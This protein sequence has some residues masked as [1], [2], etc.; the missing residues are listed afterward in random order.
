M[1]SKLFQDKNFYRAM[2]TLSTPIIIQNLITFSLGAVDMIMI[3]QLGDAPVAAVG[4]AD[5]IFFLMILMMFGVSSGAAIFSAQYWGKQ[6]IQGIHKVLSLTL[7]TA[8]AGSL[9]FLLVAVLAP[10]WALGIYTNDP[11]VIALGSDYLRVVGWSY[12]G[13][14]VAVSY[15]MLLR[16]IESVKL[17]MIVGAIALITNTTFNYLLIFGH[18]GFPRLEVTGAA[19]A[20]S[21]SRILEAVIL[22]SVIYFRRLPLA[23][24][25]KALLSIDL[26]FA[27][28]FYKTTFPVIMTEVGWSLGI[29]TYAIIYARISTES[30][31]A[32]N[33][34]VTIERMAFI[35]FLAMSS[36]CAIMIGNK[37]GANE[38]KQAYVFGKRYLLLALLTAIP[39][40]WMVALSAGAILSFYNVSETVADYA[41]MMMLIMGLVLPI[42]V[43]TLMTF[44]GILRSGGDTSYSLFLDVGSV[45]LIG[46][47]LAFIGAFVLGL[48]VYW[49]YLLVVTEEIFKV[50]I[51]LRRFFGGP[52]IHHLTE[53][54]LVAAV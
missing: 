53:P 1:L 24:N 34:V 6:D 44:I 42:K 52:W 10:E 17:P 7:A 39:I 50:T 43:T 12:L 51:G 26:G 36:A 37:I 19:L 30:I 45:W 11:E 5:Q 29:T 21:G 40:G 47:P 18:F 3:G 23:V 14:A 54:E 20:T 38:I 15:T 46:V 33:I 48:P 16:S 22:L 8:A 4:L 32:V 25:P 9:G 27:P 13:T 2:L 35:V 31:A 41:Q 28:K 49:V